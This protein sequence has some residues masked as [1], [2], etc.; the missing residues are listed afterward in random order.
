[1]HFLSSGT[2]NGSELVTVSPRFVREVSPISNAN[3]G[4]PRS[5]LT[6][7]SLIG[8]NHLQ[9]TNQTLYNFANILWSF[10]FCPPSRV[11]LYWSRS[12]TTGPTSG[13]TVFI[14][15]LLVYLDRVLL[16]VVQQGGDVGA[17]LDGRN[18]PH[19][20]DMQSDV[21]TWPEPRYRYCSR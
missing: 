14:E 1:M 21:K 12:G 15:S 19:E 3:P 7:S 6:H 10:K 2:L 5:S 18:E 4:G 20:G 17:G 8:L 9:L 13:T 16:G 11:S